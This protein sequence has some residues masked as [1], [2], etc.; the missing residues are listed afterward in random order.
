MVSALT[1]L[2]GPTPVLLSLAVAAGSSLTFL[3]GRFRAWKSSPQSVPQ[4]G[5]LGSGVAKQRLQHL[6]DSPFVHELLAR[7]AQRAH[8]S[9]HALMDGLIAQ[10]IPG[11]GPLVVPFANRAADAVER[12]IARP[13][14]GG[15]V[16]EPTPAGPAPAGG[17]DLVALL[18]E[19]Q[20]LRAALNQQKGT[21][22]A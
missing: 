6:A 20:Q 2:T 1:G 9:G 3:V 21:P 22:S 16:P 11:I 4:L 18:A 12:K 19:I 14:P 8:D 15:S 10:L 5:A 13:T 7:V 17:V